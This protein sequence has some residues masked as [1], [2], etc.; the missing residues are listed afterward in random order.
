MTAH[1]FSVPLDSR[2]LFIQSQKRSSR[3]FDK[4]QK[5]QR[6]QPSESATNPNSGF[7]GEN[8]LWTTLLAAMPIGVMV[9]TDRLRLIYCN[10][11]AKTLCERLQDE[12]D[13]S[14]PDLV[15]ELCQRLITEE[16]VTPEPLIME[17]QGAANQF[18]RLQV[19]WIDTSENRLLLVF[20][21]DCYALL[22]EE[23]AIEQAKYDLTVR[24]A[25][26]WFLLRQKYSYQEISEL[27]NITQNTV[28]T[29][30]KNIYA[31]RKN[32]ASEQKIWY[33]R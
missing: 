30:A 33:S 13:D 19:K 7:S 1:L 6:S 3:R 32:L 28:K 4:N 10:E 25:E 16:T 26:V 21:E 18:F 29:H 17:Y 23:L 22:Q 15:R 12:K 14:V 9:L 5:S 11:Q 2:F 20:L 27:L 31:K 24:E 8:A